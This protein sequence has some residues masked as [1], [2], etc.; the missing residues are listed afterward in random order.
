MIWFFRIVATLFSQDDIATNADKSGRFASANLWVK[1]SNNRPL[2]CL[3]FRLY[4]RWMQAFARVWGVQ[5]FSQSKMAVQRNA[6]TRGTQSPL[7]RLVPQLLFLCKTSQIPFTW[8]SRKAT[9]STLFSL[10]RK[11]GGESGASNKGSPVT[12]KAT[13]IAYGNHEILIK[14][15]RPRVARRSSDH[16][17]LH[18]TEIF[19]WSV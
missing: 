14:L 1:P 8:G 16:Q 3:Y 4:R 10:P 15:S 18:Q 2:Y 7:S 13:A 12:A 17:T 11:R 6:E 9:K 19:W 5:L